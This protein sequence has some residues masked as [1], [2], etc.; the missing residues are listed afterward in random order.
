MSILSLPRHPLR[1]A[2]LTLALAAGVCLASPG[3]AAA[4]SSP[5][6]EGPAP[7]ASAPV[8]SDGP[9]YGQ[10]SVDFSGGRL[11]YRDTASGFEASGAAYFE[12]RVLTVGGPGGFHYSTIRSHS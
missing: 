10:E 1:P 7:V 6:A 8:V 11:T 4:D 3:V 9:S 2:V 5:A 12:Q